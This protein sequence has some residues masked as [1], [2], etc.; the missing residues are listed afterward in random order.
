MIVFQ[1]TKKYF[2]SIAYLMRVNFIFAVYPPTL[3]PFGVGFVVLKGTPEMFRGLYS[4]KSK[5]C[6]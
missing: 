4:T 1:Y 3:C 6:I 2:N 5:G